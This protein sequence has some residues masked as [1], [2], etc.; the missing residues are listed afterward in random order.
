MPFTLFGNTHS[1]SLAQWEVKGGAQA[2]YSWVSEQVE[3]GGKINVQK[4]ENGD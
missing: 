4:G 3:K 1:Y 2:M